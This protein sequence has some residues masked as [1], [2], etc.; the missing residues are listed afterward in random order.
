MNEKILSDLPETLVGVNTFGKK[1]EFIITYNNIDE[2]VNLTFFDVLSENEKND[3]K[4][5]TIPINYSVEHGKSGIIEL[6]GKFRDLRLK[7][8]ILKEPF[9]ASE[10]IIR[11]ESI[12]L[13]EVLEIPFP[14]KESD[15]KDFFEKDKL[16]IDR[17][18]SG[19]RLKIL[20]GNFVDIEEDSIFER[21]FD[22]ES[23]GPLESY[24]PVLRDSFDSLPYDLKRF[25]LLK[26]LKIYGDY[27]D[28]EGNAYYLDKCNDSWY[29]TVHPSSDREIIGIEDLIVI[30][31]NPIANHMRKYTFDFTEYE[32]YSTELDIYESKFIYNGESHV[33]LTNEKEALEFYNRSIS[34]TLIHEFTHFLD[35]NVVLSG[36]F[37]EN[38]ITEGIMEELRPKLDE[39]GYYNGSN[40]PG[41]FIA[42]ASPVYFENPEYLKE[43]LPII[44]ETINEIISSIYN[45]RQIISFD[46]LVEQAR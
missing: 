33:L 17:F 10:Y 46:K 9:N 5:T 21:I 36:Y 42:Y 40:D 32:Y 34:G 16:V 26:K 35:Y 7:P 43:E 22:I 25:A 27:S 13:D 12:Y 19:K 4:G 28:I 38:I 11:V 24:I 41:E 44:Y 30:N 18:V 29:K 14:F 8:I 6:Y 20:N 39:I 37:S 23:L 45:D 2:Y 31:T 3:L 1:R 15:F